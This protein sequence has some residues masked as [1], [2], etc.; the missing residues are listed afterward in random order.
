MGMRTR[1]SSRASTHDPYG[2][3]N[4]LLGL[5]KGSEAS[6]M[7]VSHTARTDDKFPLRGYAGPSGRL[8]VIARSLVAAS[9]TRGS[10]FIASLLGPPDPPKLLVFRGCGIAS[11]RAAM[12]EI[13]K[14]LGGRGSGCGLLLDCWPEEAIAAAKRAGYRV[15]VLDEGGADI[16]RV[17][18]ALEG[19]ALFVLGPH[20]DPP[21]DLWRKIIRLSDY[22]VSIGPVSLH[23]SHVILYLAWARGV[24]VGGGLRALKSGGEQGQDHSGPLRQDR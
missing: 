2:A 24:L 17:R 20:V 7:V 10:V 4:E 13:R 22:V 12:L 8:D 15:V 9:L 14:L 11:E 3:Y 6:Y 19:K 21:R 1:A 23:T 5:L 18:A 16:S